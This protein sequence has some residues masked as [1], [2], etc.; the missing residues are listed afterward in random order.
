VSKQLNVDQPEKLLIQLDWLAGMLRISKRKLVERA[1]RELIDSEFRR[2][3][4]RE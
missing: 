2:L 1:L 4:V 3:G